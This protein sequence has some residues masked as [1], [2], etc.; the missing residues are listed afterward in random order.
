MARMFNVDER[1]AD[2]QCSSTREPVQTEMRLTLHFAQ[3]LAKAGGVFVQHQHNAQ[4]A[5]YAR[6]Q[7]LGK[8]D[9]RKHPIKFDRHEMLFM[10]D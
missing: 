7:K 8:G 3:M 6:I 10:I 5:E 9:V 4:D 1:V 2:L